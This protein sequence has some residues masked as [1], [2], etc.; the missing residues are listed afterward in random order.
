MSGLQNRKKS[1]VPITAAQENLPVTTAAE[2]RSTPVLAPTV[3]GNDLVTFC[4]M[5]LC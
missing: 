4:L 1:K 2:Q 3:S 5:L